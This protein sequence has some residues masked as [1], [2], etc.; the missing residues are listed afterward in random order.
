[1]RPLDLAAP[2]VTTTRAADALTL[3]ARLALPVDAGPRFSLTAIVEQS[4][5]ALSYWALAHASA[6]PDFHHPDSFVL[7]LETADLP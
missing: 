1:M 6:K 4:N 2:E 7:N 3:A 5:G